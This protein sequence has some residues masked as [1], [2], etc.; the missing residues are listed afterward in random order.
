MKLHA[1]LACA[2]A[3]VAWLG[4]AQSQAQTSQ[5]PAASPQ[6]CQ[7]QCE[8]RVG[9]TCKSLPDGPNKLQCNRDLSACIVNCIA[10]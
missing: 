8:Q 5:P 2:T 3:G 1:F 7:S 10:K 4:P 9:S 6:L